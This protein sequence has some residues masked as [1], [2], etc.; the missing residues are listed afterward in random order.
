MDV[1]DPGKLGQ[2]GHETWLFFALVLPP[3]PSYP[4]HMHEE[5][6]ASDETTATR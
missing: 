1:F 2:I 5:P 4:R 3:Y 6:S